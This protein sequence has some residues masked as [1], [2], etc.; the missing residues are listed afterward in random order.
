MSAL[1]GGSPAPVDA[2]HEAGRRNQRA[3]QHEPVAVAGVERRR[4]DP[5]VAGAGGALEVG[6]KVAPEAAGR[7]DGGGD[8]CPFGKPA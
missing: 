4:S 6:R 1:M 8:S 5:G 2:G 3:E 7:V